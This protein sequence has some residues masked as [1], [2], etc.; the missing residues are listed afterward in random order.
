M[1]PQQRASKG[2]REEKTPYET[3]DI[4]NLLTAPMP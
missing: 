4:E 1:V 2:I 3:D